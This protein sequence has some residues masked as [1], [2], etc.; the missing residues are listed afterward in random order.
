MKKLK[1]T[2]A[3]ILIRLAFKFVPGNPK[4]SEV[5]KTLL[6]YMEKKII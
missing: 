1:L 3:K 6:E 2:T 5:L 4:K